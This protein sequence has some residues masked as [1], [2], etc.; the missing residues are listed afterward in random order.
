[1]VASKYIQISNRGTLDRKFIEL[2]GL[3]TKSETLGNPRKIGFKGSG[4]K[5]A[6]VA[7][8]RLG[9]QT[10]ISSTDQFGR[11][12]LVFDS[13]P[14][15]VQGVP[16]RQVHYV[17]YGLTPEGEVKI[18]QRF[19]SHL[20]MEAFADWDSPV[21]DDDQR[22]FKVLREHLTNAVDEDCDY[23]VSFTDQ[24][25]F[26]KPGET[27][28][29]LANTPEIAAMLDHPTR[30][31]KFR[32]PGEPAWQSAHGQIYAKSEPDRSRLFIVGVLVD[33]FRE[34]LQSTVFDYSLNDKTMLSEER[35]LKERGGFAF[36]LGQLLAG[37][38]QVGIAQM[39]LGEI[40]LGRARFE[41]Q[42]LGTV[43]DFQLNDRSKAVWRAA[44]EAVWG[45]RICISGNDPNV[46]RD[47]AD[48]SRYKVVGG[49]SHSLRSFLQRLGYPEAINV[50]PHLDESD[51]DQ[52][53]FEGFD[54]ASRSR[55]LSAYG[56]LVRHFP[57]RAQY[58]VAFYLPL[59]ERLN[60]TGGL[61]MPGSSGGYTEAWVRAKSPT[62]LGTLAS[63]L[64]AL[65]HETRHCITG[66]HDAERPFAGLAD[67]EVVA[68]MLREAAID[69]QAAGSSLPPR[70][71][72]QNL[73]PK[74]LPLKK[75]Q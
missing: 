44:A 14:I 42:A 62:E 25:F 26:A 70:G 58:P 16:H 57:E 71:A 23:R 37:L 59:S 1:M 15:A 54:E 61:A 72:P 52:L 38:D 45:S 19:P 13:E 55:F 9:L 7:G 46:N 4:L 73:P 51:Y 27:S 6:A 49:S 12:V 2:I 64:R 5:L 22:A 75:K 32:A 60:N 36:R 3:T 39:I 17:Y 33:C 29:F 10:A 47:A 63:I 11:Y 24:T 20:V 48:I 40:A 18:V 67:K 69:E 34:H 50:V 66:A 68:L 35:V 41:E 31:F 53:P 43:Y 65:V 56:L 28:V 21:G 30:Y 8:L 74:F